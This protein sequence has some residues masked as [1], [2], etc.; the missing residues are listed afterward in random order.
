[1]KNVLF[2]TLEGFDFQNPANHLIE[3]L[4]DDLLLNGYF[5]TLVQSNR[6]RTNQSVP[7]ILNNRANLRIINID[8]KIVKKSS[9]LLRYLEEVFYQL[10]AFLI[11]NKIKRID[12]F[13]LQSSP[14]IYITFLLV[15]FIKKIP[16]ILTIQDVWPG[17]AIHSGVLKNKF[18][19]FLFSF[20]QKKVYQGASLL[21]V[22][23][24]DMKNIVVNLGI[25]EAKI[26]VIPNWFN[27]DEIK[28]ISWEENRFVKKYALDK[29]K[30]YIL[31]AGTLGFVFDFQMILE[32]SKLFLSIKQVE[33]LII[34]DGSQ[35]SLFVQQANINGLS[36]IRFFPLEPQEMV[37]DVYSS[38]SVCIIPLKKGI[39]GNSVPSKA[40]LIMACRRTIVNSVDENSL[41]YSFFNS[42]KIG[43][44]SSNSSSKDV[45]NSLYKLYTNPCLNNFYSENAY[46]LSKSLFSKKIN[47]NKFICL[48]DLLSQ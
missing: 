22:I 7:K 41:Y 32:V 2:F 10:K 29:N 12:L 20:I 39:I 45:F 28:E 33:F 34:G 31:Y 42:L 3:S 1:M 30:F 36:N 16:I 46:K 37:S 21:T 4:I 23:S 27:D 43:I 47:T 35:K 15:K 13:Y 48:F 18:L 6:I 40:A 26:F 24:N 5:V 14:A 11:W 9:F 25:K 44:S 19:I 38:S 17:S 8:R